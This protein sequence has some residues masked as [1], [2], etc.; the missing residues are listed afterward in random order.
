MIESNNRS[1]LLRQRTTIS[2]REIF[3]NDCL[4]LSFHFS[5]YTFLLTHRFQFIHA[6]AVIYISFVSKA[7]KL[8][9]PLEDIFDP[10]AEVTTSKFI[11]LS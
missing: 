7:R 5:L 4:T 11:Y 6:G 3:E 8:T 1:I 10:L 9:V 2:A